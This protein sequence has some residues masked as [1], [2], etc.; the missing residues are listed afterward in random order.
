MCVKEVYR[1]QVVDRAKVQNKVSLC[2]ALRSEPIV[3]P[4]DIN[5]RASLVVSDM[6]RVKVPGLRVVPSTGES[7]TATDYGGRSKND[8]RCMKRNCCGKE[9]RY[10]GCRRDD[11]LCIHRGYSKSKVSWAETT[12]SR[13]FT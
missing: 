6:R 2:G 4:E 8:L 12:E 9:N 7:I 1:L 5:D 10:K 13:L 11:F 3:D